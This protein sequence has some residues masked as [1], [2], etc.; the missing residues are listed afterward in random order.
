[1]TSFYRRAL[2]ALRGPDAEQEMNEELRAHIEQATERL[3]ARGL[4]PEAAAIEAR[5]EFGNRAVIEDDARNARGLRWLESIVADVRYAARHLMRHKLTTTTI[6]LVLSLG[7]GAN[8]TVFTV[9]RA[10]TSRPA[11][12]VPDDDALVEVYGLRQAEKGTRW[13]VRRF[14]HGEV[15]A[16]RERKEL[17][18]GVA[19][20]T[21]DEVILHSDAWGPRDVPV[22][23]VTGNYFS[24]LGIAMHLGRPLQGNDGG[25]DD[26]PV[27]DAV[28]SHRW[29]ENRFEGSDTVIGAVVRL[30]KQDVRIVGVAPPRFAGAIPDD[31]ESAA[32]WIPM[33]ARAALLESPPSWQTNPDST[34]FT[35]FGRLLPGVTREEAT[36]IAREVGVAANARRASPA[37]RTEVWSSFVNPLRSHLMTDEPITIF[38]LAGISLGALLILLVTCTNVSSLLVASAVSRRHEIAV[39]LSLGASRGRVVRQLIT[40]SSMLAIAGGLLGMVL[41]SFLMEGLRLN[42]QS[43]DLSPSAGTLAFTMGFA[44]ATG[45]LFGLSPALHGTRGLANAVK[46]SASG[47]RRS[48]LQDGFIVAQIAL[49]QPLLVLLAFLLFSATT[50]ME[51]L[52]T[53]D[54]GE[55]VMDFSFAVNESKPTAKARLAAIGAAMD[56][57]AQE[58]GVVSIVPDPNWFSGIRLSLPD[59]DRATAEGPQALGARHS[60]VS[61]AAPGYFSIIGTRILR[62]R[63]V[64]LA[65][66]TGPHGSDI[67]IV[68]PS[69][70]ARDFWGAADPLGRRVKSNNGSIGWGTGFSDHFVVVGVYESDEA[71]SNRSLAA[72]IY[73][74]RGKRWSKSSFLARTSGPA[75]PMLPKMRELLAEFAHDVPGRRIE[76]L[77]QRLYAKRKDQRNVGIAVV[78]GVALAMSLT[79]IG[80]YGLVALAVRQRQREIGVRIAIGGK[81]MRVAGMFFA[82]G[83]KLSAIGLAIGLPLSGAVLW[84]GAQQMLGGGYLNVPL[85]LASVAVVV[86]GVSSIATWIP[87]RRAANV[88]PVIAL[89]AE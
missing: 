59:D 57:I 10:I 24:T 6:I 76:T 65:D 8:T 42:V 15:L 71:S 2:N 83:L 66:T 54:V 49:T 75:L 44:I 11:P 38:I 9:V 46:D 45:V 86:V 28:I 53:E 43:L 29:W 31:G 30:N 35:V 18:E 56:R 84:V 77:N 36:P 80:L 16:L 25:A 73:T 79:S 17:F 20:F 60:F 39:R 72:R 19:G 1:M 34:V 61:G 74:A 33:S 13:S 81:P 63:D 55:R 14:S 70:M 89:R 37:A 50:M 26:Q 88:D 62:G 23:F 78:G 52:P 47:S 22:E 64:S 58:P 41:Y 21:F 67:P 32:F 27:L 68:I 7:I 3:V 69:D 4:S 5:R 48:R 40:E 82:N 12:G 85:L 87:A 51:K